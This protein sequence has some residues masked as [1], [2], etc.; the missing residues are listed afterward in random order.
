MLMGRKNNIKM[1]KL[2]L[3]CLSIFALCNTGYSQT[4]VYNKNLKISNDI[5]REL[6]IVNTKKVYSADEVISEFMAN[7]VRAINT[8]KELFIIKGRIAKIFKLGEKN[9]LALSVSEDDEA[10]NFLYVHIQ[11]THMY[12]SV[13]NFDKITNYSVGDWVNIFSAYAFETKEFSYNYLFM[14]NILHTKT[15]YEKKNFLVKIINLPL[16]AKISHHA[17]NQD[18]A[19]KFSEVNNGKSFCKLVSAYG[20]T[21]LEVEIKDSNGNVLKKAKIFAKINC[22]ST[23]DYNKL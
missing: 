6:V 4:Y 17:E 12:Q 2:I 11:D 14:G 22:I 10:Q 13:H 23:F 7:E 18:N 3:S 15:I 8:F 20:K 1:N 19:T 5:A 9:F 16:G 21:G